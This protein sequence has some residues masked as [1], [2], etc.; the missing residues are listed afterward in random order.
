MKNRNLIFK[1]LL[2]ITLLFVYSFNINADTAG[3]GCIRI[4]K[5]TDGTPSHFDVEGSTCTWS[6][7]VGYESFSLD[8]YPSAEEAMQYGHDLLD[9]QL[10]KIK[11]TQNIEIYEQAKNT[12]SLVV[13]RC[14]SGAAAIATDFSC[15]ASWG[16]ANSC[17][18]KMKCWDWDEH[19]RCTDYDCDGYVRVCSCGEYYQMISPSGKGNCCK[20]CEMDDCSFDGDKGDLQKA[21]NWS[22]FNSKGIYPKSQ[23]R[24]YNSTYGDKSD[25]FSVGTFF[26]LNG[27][28]EKEAL[29][30]YGNSIKNS[31]N[32]SI[33]D[34]ELKANVETENNDHIHTSDHVHNENTTKYNTLRE[35]YE[36]WNHIPSNRNTIYNF[37]KN[38]YEAYTEADVYS[39]C[40]VYG[41][42]GY[43]SFKSCSCNVSYSLKCPKYE[44]TPK[45]TTSGVCTPE[46]RA[47]S[48]NASM[49]AVNPALN[50][51]YTTGNL[52]GYADNELF[53]I[54]NSFDYRSCNTSYQSEECGYSNILIESQYIK[55][56]GTDEQKELLD[57]QT[58]NLALR[59]YGGHVASRGYIELAG[60]GNTR[61]EPGEDS[62]CAFDVVYTFVPSSYKITV[63][64]LAEFFKYVT[65]TYA[66]SNQN[67]AY[68]DYVNPISF[69]DDYTF[70]FPCNGKNLGAMCHVSDKT[71]KRNRKTRLAIGLYFN[72]I[73]GNPRMKDHRDEL[74]GYSLNRPQETELIGDGKDE[75]RVVVNYG[76]IHV[77]T[78]Q[79]GVKYDCDHLE[80]LDENLA[81][82]IRRYCNI[83]ITYNYVKDGKEYS[84]G[85]MRPEYCSGKHSLR[86]TTRKINV[87]VCDE[88]R[89]SQTV[90]Y[91]YRT[92]ESGQQ[93]GGPVK[94][95]ACNSPDK[96]TQL[97]GIV[98]GEKIK[99]DAKE[100][101]YS[102]S[103]WECDKTTCTDLKLRIKDA[104]AVPPKDKAEYDAK[105]ENDVSKGHVKDPSL[106]CI[107]NASAENK[108]KYDF[109]EIFGVNTNFCRVYC[110][111]EVNYYIPDRI[112][113]RDGLSLKYD[114]AMRSYLKDSNNHLISSV[115]KEK[116]TCV[117]EIYYNSFPRTINWGTIYG[118]KITDQAKAL[119][120]ENE[121]KKIAKPI[122]NWEKLFKVLKSLKGSSAK[123]SDGNETS[124]KTVSENLNEIIYDIYNCNF[125]TA[126]GESNMFK[127]NKI[128]RPR[129]RAFGG[130][131]LNQNVYDHYIAK[132]FDVSNTYGLHGGFNTNDAKCTC[133]N[134]NNEKCEY[135]KDTGKDD[136]GKLD[137]MK[138]EY[139]SYKAGSEMV[140]N[141]RIGGTSNTN[142]IDLEN[143]STGTLS[144]V[145]YCR[146]AEAIDKACFGYALGTTNGSKE[147]LASYNYERMDG[148]TK[149][150]ELYEDRSKK[151]EDGSYKKVTAKVPINDYA[152]FTVTTEV[153]FYN[154]S[155]FQPEPSTGKVSKVAGSSKTTRLTLDKYTYPISKD[156][157]ALC[158]Y[159]YTKEKNWYY[160][161]TDNTRDNLYF[162][163]YK[164]VEYSN[165]S[166]THK[167]D[168]LNTYHRLQFND[169]FYS[170]ISK[171]MASTYYEVTGSQSQ[172]PPGTKVCLQ[173]MN[174]V[175]EYRN[176]DRSNVFPHQEISALSSIE[177]NWDTQEGRQAVKVIEETDTRAF[178]NNDI[179]QYSFS[180][181]PQQIK[182][183]RSYNRTASD[184]VDVKVDNCVVDERGIY[185]D[186][187]VTEESILDQIRKNQNDASSSGY[188]S[189][190]DGKDGTNLKFN[191]ADEG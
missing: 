102:V 14:D 24:D 143:V 65:E 64:M 126:K 46:Y 176:V 183:I 157:F 189:I 6:R 134:S 129:Q 27:I 99:E 161:P 130:N 170:K 61:S 45:V 2:F 20:K 168:T 77:D 13:T 91:N 152:I 15:T 114:I 167:Y 37:Y 62:S 76:D 139:I 86:C 93:K 123:F 85:P 11:N 19:G 149:T 172:C 163:Y 188:A 83:Q 173:G 9:K 122:D 1:I 70:H 58:I 186:C 47:N 59:L 38:H 87:A 29:N 169:E 96:I 185:L 138:M 94:M 98:G 113:I 5:T 52:G 3:E 180:L 23:I 25:N 34:Y 12:S 78:I 22:D 109:S 151:M 154:N 41:E 30:H 53:K 8:H 184:Y 42:A 18:N 111:D 84:E 142:K 177:T 48:L 110:S 150:Y 80:G 60:L 101:T 191:F 103:S 174:D 90:T 79:T 141:S 100:V 49:Y 104:S 95:I 72:T 73:M 181:T 124:G 35:E 43:G 148:K 125:F 26:A 162:G 51:S 117:S 187:K 179:V 108:L 63:N 82:H 182:N 4:D 39:D 136:T 71:K 159:N 133:Y 175:G 158:N 56:K 89:I 88:N 118:F 74:F 155:R 190:N 17:N 28:S 145:E 57:Y 156:A 55:E 160:E 115:V 7:I 171:Y 69:I 97:Y 107:L 120:W 54:D 178:I 67:Y 40:N 121:E 147:D 119:G 92:V 112:N 106:K 21:G 140:E 164:P 33:T 146:D 135:N 36:G 166:V 127:N 31:W 144:K 132:E 50:F 68:G 137:C 131:E 10:E 105:P 153:G 165:C 128:T 32:T 66:V 44:C 81:N 75:S 116:R 16:A